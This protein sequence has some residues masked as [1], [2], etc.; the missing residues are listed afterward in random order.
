MRRNEIFC[1]KI[2]C[3]ESHREQK[4]N[5]GHQGWGDINGIVD[6]GG[7][8]P[9]LCPKCMAKIKEFLNGELD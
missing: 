5:E 3:K 8:S 2:G 7:E 4:F 6:A 9:H 1:S